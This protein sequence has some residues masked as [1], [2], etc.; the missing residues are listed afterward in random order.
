[1]RRWKQRRGVNQTIEA[2]KRSGH[3]MQS[4]ANGFAVSNIERQPNYILHAAKCRGLR[5]DALRGL[6][7]AV[8]YHNVRS[9]LRRLQCNFAPDP[10]APA[11]NDKDLAAKLSLRRGGAEFR[12]F[13]GPV[14]DAHP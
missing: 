14:F 1:M 12:F 10:A 5:C 11:N 3:R 6:K 13:E 8:G 4:M 9:A 2:A 7:I